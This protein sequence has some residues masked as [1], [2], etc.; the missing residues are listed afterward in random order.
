L[1]AVPAIFQLIVLPFCPESPKYLLVSKNQPEAAKKALI[2]LRQKSD[3]S[4]ELDEMKM[5]LSKQKASP[6]LRFVDMFTDKVLRWALIIAAMMML[7]Q[8]FSGIN[9]VMF[10]STR[11]FRDAAHL[12]E[13]EAQRATLGIGAINILMTLIS[14]A[15]IDRAGRRSLHLGGLGGM[16]VCSI[17]LTVFMILTVSIDMLA[18]DHNCKQ[19]GYA[20]AS[21]MSI[22]FLL[23][24]VVSF[25]IGP[26]PIPWFFVSELFNQ[27]ARGHA[28]SV[29]V[30]I[31]WFAAFIVCL[32][33]PP[34]QTMINQYTF[35]I[36]AALL[37]LFW[38]FTYKYVPETKNR[39]VDDVVRELREFVNRH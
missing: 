1:T 19:Y 35:L 17:M 29:V 34:L 33:F 25:A 28:T 32:A 10:Y 13:S 18:F 27:N 15:I 7:S 16:W 36:F 8:Q 3:V 38:L 20:W 24:F 22:L 6:K 12:Q 11:I 4:A 23:G 9:A 5:E 14:T 26:G 37:T 30:P 31:N 21:Y 39:T 2:K